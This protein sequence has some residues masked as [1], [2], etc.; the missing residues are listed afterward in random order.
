MDYMKSCQKDKQEDGE[1]AQVFK[2][3]YWDLGLITSTPNHPFNS[4]SRESGALFSSCGHQYTYD[5]QKTI[6]LEKQKQVNL[7]KLEA[8]LVYIVSSIQN[9][10]GC[11]DRP[12]F[13]PPPQIYEEMGNT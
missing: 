5:A 4:S 8:N 6:C 10:Q 11:V 7:C 12:C 3:A 13:K 9:S 2:G 1:L